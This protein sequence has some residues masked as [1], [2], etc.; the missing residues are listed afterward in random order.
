MGKIK[1]TSIFKI[2]SNSILS[3]YGNYILTDLY[4]PIIGSDSFSLYLFL[5]YKLKENKKTLSVEEI[6]LGCNFNINSFLEAKKL[7]EGVGLIKTYE[8]EQDY[9]IVL[10]STKSPKEY[11]KD[12]VLKGLL[13]QAIGKEKFEKILSKFSNKIDRAGYKEITSSF[14]DAFNVDL[15][16]IDFSYNIENN[17]FLIDVKSKDPKFIFDTQYFMDL[18]EKDYKITKD[19]LNV[20][21]LK[22]IKKLSSL[23]SISED[24]MAIKLSENINYLGEP[25]K[26]IDFKSLEESCYDDL[27]FVSVNK[28]KK[29]KTEKISSSTN[30]A[31]KIEIMENYS[32]LQYLSLK[33]GNTAVVRSDANLINF[34]SLKLGLENAVINALIDYVLE[35]NDQDP[36]LAHRKPIFQRFQVIDHKMDSVFLHF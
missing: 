29:N 15:D 9:L 33:Q 7:L 36:Q 24:N 26:R 3:D 21:A 12:I 8:K 6:L 30:I 35:K 16:N 34:L 10:Y 1:D 13:L 23:Y 25:G 11:F 4:L 28:K 22:V 19:D 20:S 32:P 31:K 2:D 18:C 27:I 14:S 5:V 17:D